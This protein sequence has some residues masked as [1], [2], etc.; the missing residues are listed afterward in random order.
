MIRKVNIEE[1]EN[2][3]TWEKLIDCI[4]A[5]ATVIK[6]NY[7]NKHFYSHHTNKLRSID[8]GPTAVKQEKEFSWL[9]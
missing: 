4:L 2:E 1:N 6:M 3:R 8:M 5:Q 7:K 9:F